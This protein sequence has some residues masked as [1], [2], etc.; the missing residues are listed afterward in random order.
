[1]QSIQFTVDNLANVNEFLNE[2][3]QL[4]LRTVYRPS[5]N[6]P[7]D[8][9]IQVAGI[10]INYK[11]YIVKENSDFVIYTEEDYLQAFGNKNDY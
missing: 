9:Y 6:I 5:E 8:Y 10:T 2:N 11:D 3:L 7:S 4:M 1:M